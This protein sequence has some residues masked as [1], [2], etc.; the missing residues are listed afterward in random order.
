MTDFRTKLKPTVESL[1]SSAPV[2]WM[3]RLRLKDQALILAYHNVVPDGVSVEG[4]RSLHLPV[5]DFARQMD[6]L[7]ECA[8]VVPLSDVVAGSW[9]ASRGSKPRVAITFDDAYLG[10]IA[11]ALPELR[12]RNLPSTV[13]VT[14]GLLGG[15]TF[16]WDALRSPGG[17]PVTELIRRHAICHLK[18]QG[19]LVESWGFGQGLPISEANPYATTVSEGDLRIASRDPLL[20]LGSH[21]WSHPNLTEIS[22]DELLYELLE[23]RAWLESRFPNVIPWLSYPYGCSN[24]RIRDAAKRAGYHAAVEIEGNWFSPR[25]ANPFALPRIN[26]PAGLSAEGFSARL[27]G[28][29]C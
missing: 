7:K 9:T 16:W 14:P 15:Q 21:S 20:T 24:E 2:S 22:D 13:F 11:V 1:M 10:A 4:D 12:K 5:G 26:I 25:Q 17:G 23:S 18:G 8:D 29:L 19:A 6:I 3:G 28:L 27:S